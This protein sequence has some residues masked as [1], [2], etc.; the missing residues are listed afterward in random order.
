MG[1]TSLEKGWEVCWEGFERAKKNEKRR[2]RGME[3]K[4][5]GKRRESILCVSGDTNP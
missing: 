1:Q 3:R 4:V 5:G 2:G